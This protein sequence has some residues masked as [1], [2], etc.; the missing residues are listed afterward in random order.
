MPG[1]KLFGVGRSNNEEGDEDDDIAYASADATGRDDH[2]AAHRHLGGPCQRFRPGLPI[3]I[4]LVSVLLLE[5]SRVT[6]VNILPVRRLCSLLESGGHDERYHNYHLY[7]EA[8]SRGREERPG[9]AD[10]KLP[11]AERESVAEF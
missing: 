11:V 6:L 3:R 5:L 8:Q 9:R 4:R 7:L 1:K 2:V 10:R